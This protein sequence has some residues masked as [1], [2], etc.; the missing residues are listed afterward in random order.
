LLG[1]N[2]HRCFRLVAFVSVAADETPAQD[3]ERERPL[4]DVAL[5]LCA[6]SSSGQAC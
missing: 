2:R 6:T 4:A 5:L 3:D 1:R